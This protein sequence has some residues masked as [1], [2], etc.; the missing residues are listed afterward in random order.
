[1]NIASIGSLTE[2][3]KFGIESAASTK[4]NRN[5][6]FESLFEAAK[7]LIEETNNYTNAA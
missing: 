3:S 5:A 1:M 2:L 7:N 4:E 6:T